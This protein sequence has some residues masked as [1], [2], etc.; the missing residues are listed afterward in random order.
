MFAEAVQQNIFMTWMLRF[1]VTVGMILAFRL[2]FG[3]FQESFRNIPPARYF[4]AW[5]KGPF[6]AVLGLGLS[7]AAISIA[8]VYHRPLISVIS[9]AV[10]AATA[11]AIKVF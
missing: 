7:L 11:F 9:L 10:L 3:V 6:S 1:M 2:I 8:W 4:I 5:G